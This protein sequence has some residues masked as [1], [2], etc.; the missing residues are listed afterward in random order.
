MN[1]E[2]VLIKSIIS[3]I[4][5]GKIFKVVF[6]GDSLTSAE[7]VHPNWREIIEYVVKYKLEPQFK[8]WWMSHWNL[9]FINSGVDGGTT[10]DFLEYLKNEVLGYEA[11]LVICMGTDNDRD[12]KM[13]IEEQVQNVN[14]IKNILEEKVSHFVYATDTASLDPRKDLEYSKYVNRILEL[15]VRKNEI[16]INM[17]EE[18]SKFDLNSFFTFKLGDEAADMGYTKGEIDPVHPNPLGNAYIAK[19]ML[20]KIFGFQFDPER[21]LQDLLSGEKTP[22]FN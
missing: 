14:E 15:P 4:N 22:S 6:L 5:D 10:K 11:D 7:W 3:K 1:T 8:D 16:F 9:R 12:N 20:D 17:L 21:Y 2:N 13:T 19:I 18:F